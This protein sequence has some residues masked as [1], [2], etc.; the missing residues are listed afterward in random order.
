MAKQKTTTIKL[1]K[2]TKSRLDRLK[3]HEK[4]S[5][6]ETIKK[7]LNILNITQRSPMLGARI[8]RDIERGKK[9]GRLIDNPEKIIRRRLAPKTPLQRIE[10]NL[11]SIQRQPVQSQM[12]RREM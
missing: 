6:E 7:A 1:T 12:Q 3:E 8:L 9:R 2:D 11:K 10:M 5:Y 4:E